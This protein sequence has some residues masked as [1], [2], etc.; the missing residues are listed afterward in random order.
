MGIVIHRN[1]KETE[2]QGNLSLYAADYSKNVNLK[3][4][5]NVVPTY[6]IEYLP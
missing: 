1:L 2:Y 4:Y 3:K 6:R 5:C